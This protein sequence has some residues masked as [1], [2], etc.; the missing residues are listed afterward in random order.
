MIWTGLYIREGGET[1]KG[2]RS[3]RQ[4]IGTRL[5]LFVLRCLVKVMVWGWCWSTASSS[6]AAEVKPLKV[7]GQH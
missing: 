7:L 1:G 3:F 5:G 2:K 6:Q 4:S